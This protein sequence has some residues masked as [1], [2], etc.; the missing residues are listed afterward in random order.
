M[1][2]SNPF[3]VYVV[4]QF[5]IGADYARVFEYLE[6]RDNFFY[7]NLTNPEA[8]PAESS[9]EVLQETVRQQMKDAEVVILPAGVLAGLSPMVDFQVTVAQAFKKP[10]VLIQPFGAT[11]SISREVLEAAAESV[12]WNERAII[13]AIR[14]AARGED[15]S[16]WD[17][18]EFDLDG[19]DLDMDDDDR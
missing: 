11:V 7:I 16:T 8:V 2:E 13:D 3:K 14:R 6:S 18:I 5:S 9:P 12:D 19:I 15:T 1:S 17:V 4:H 10:I